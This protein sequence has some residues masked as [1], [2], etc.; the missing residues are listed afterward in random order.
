MFGELLS[1]SMMHPESVTLMC[2]LVCLLHPSP[3]TLILK[4][5]EEALKHSHT[6]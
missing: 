2:D 3:I 4:E 5:P 1:Y 6:E